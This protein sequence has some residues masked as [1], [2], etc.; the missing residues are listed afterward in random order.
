[1]NCDNSCDECFCQGQTL[2]LSAISAQPSAK[3]YP[4]QEQGWSPY[5]PRF[6]PFCGYLFKAGAVSRI[7]AN[8]GDTDKCFALKFEIRN[9][10]HETNTKSEF[11]NVQNITIQRDLS[12]VSVIWILV[13]R[14]CFGFRYSDFGFTIAM[15]LCG[16]SSIRSPLAFMMR[17]KVTNRY[18]IPIFC[19]QRPL[20]CGFMKTLGLARQNSVLIKI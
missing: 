7:F 12:S 10:K 20:P 1:M 3:I 13:I 18:S 4:G 6:L 14:I 11:S 15:C 16:E 19:A 17:S 8:H 9:P 5:R 2:E